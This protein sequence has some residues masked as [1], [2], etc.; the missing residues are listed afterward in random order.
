MHVPNLRT[1]GSHRD[2][3]PAETSPPRIWRSLDE[4]ADTPQF[5]EALEREFA[6]HAVTWGDLTSRRDFLH[7]MGAWIA[8]A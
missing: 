5:R 7:G 2:S 3:K 1:A 4:L 6:P 8:L